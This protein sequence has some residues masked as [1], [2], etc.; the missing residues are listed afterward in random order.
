MGEAGRADRRQVRRLAQG[1]AR[2]RDQH[3]P[4][5]RARVGGE[6]DRADVA[7]EAAGRPRRRARPR[8]RPQPRPR[9]PPAQPEDDAADRGVGDDLRRVRL[10]RAGLPEPQPDD[11]AAPAD[12]PAAR[13][14][15]PAGGLAGAAGAARGVRV[16]RRSRPA[17]PTAPASS[18]ARSG[19][20]PASW[21]RNCAR[22]RHTERRRSGGAGDGEALG[23]RSRAPRAPACGSAARWR[24]APSAA[25]AL[26][27]RRPRAGCRRRPREGAAAVYVPSC[28]N[29][30]FG[31]LRRCRGAAWLEALV[32]VSARAGLPVWIPDDVAGSCCGLPWS[33]KGFGEA[34]RHK[35]NEMVERLWALERRG[36]AADRDRRR[37]LHP[38]D[39]RPRRGRPRRGERRAPRRAR[40]PRLGRLG[41]RP[42]AARLEVAA[43]GRLG[44]RPPDLRHPPHG[45][46]AAGS[47]RSPA[48]SPTTSTSPPR[49][50]AAAS[51][52]TAAS[53]TRS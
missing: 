4:L 14:G 27:R 48:P 32:A 36:G 43:Q 12:R 19:S 33:S 17:P 42:P 46:R 16:R 1:R 52:A 21:S 18:P 28:T 8:R 29:R 20:T 6:G 3:G 37:L 22:E 45:P 31:R 39:R 35:A 38:G 47:Q 40:D 2:D 24:A 9:R 11:D 25:R 49:R 15:A 10:L 53:P 30:I 51:P 13:D 23:R 5:C 50:P 34:H 26:P 41:A 7:G 44:H